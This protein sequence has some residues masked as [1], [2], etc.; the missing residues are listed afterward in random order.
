MYSRLLSMLKPLIEIYI[1]PQN[2]KCDVKTVCPPPHAIV[3]KVRKKPGV[4]T[5]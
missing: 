3:L 1:P 4:I 2:C 5:D